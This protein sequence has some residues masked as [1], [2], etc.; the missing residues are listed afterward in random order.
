MDVSI[1]L[2][3]VN[4]NNDLCEVRGTDRETLY[5]SLDFILELFDAFGQLRVAP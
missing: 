1:Y 4:Q 3:T 2:D 5:C